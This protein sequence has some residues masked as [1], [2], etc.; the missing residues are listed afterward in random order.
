MS[1]KRKRHTTSAKSISPHRR[2]APNPTESSPPAI[3]AEE[4]L[5]RMPAAKARFARSLA[6]TL[7]AHY[8]RKHA[9]PSTSKQ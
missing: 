3:D 8:R 1:A 9:Q 5:S 7:V 2:Q 4:Y 6:D